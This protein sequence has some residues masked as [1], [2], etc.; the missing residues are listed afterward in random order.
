M[1]ERIGEK[2]QQDGAATVDRPTIIALLAALL[3]LVFA[4][5]AGW[6]VSLLPGWR[7]SMEALRGLDPL[8][9]HAVLAAIEVLLA[10]LLVFVV[11]RLAPEGTE[12]RRGPLAWLGLTAS[13]LPAL[14]V[15]G[16]AVLPA[17]LVFALTQPL[18]RAVVGFGVLYLAFIGPFA[19]EVVFRGVAFGLL[20]RVAGWPF[21]A[22]A[23]MP[24]VVF[25]LGHANPFHG[26]P[27]L[28]E[29]MTFAITATGAVIFAWLYERW[30]FDLWVPFLLHA[31]MN[32]AWSLFRVGDGAFA[33]WLPL[34]MQVTTVTL[35][36]LLSIHATKR[37]MG[38]D[39]DGAAGP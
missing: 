28:D 16:L 38:P 32:L 14:R 29:I 20:R 30:R 10:W 1:T 5:R 33:G 31:L 22:A 34:V 15:I 37:R 27:S 2:G 7:R 17:Y 6:V 9:P 39:R 25:G 3:I 8:A 23:G 18:N 24:A 35:A 13:P 4:L 11:L 36:I 12:E 21:W 19:E 26:A